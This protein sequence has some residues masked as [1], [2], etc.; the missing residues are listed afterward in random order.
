[1]PGRLGSQQRQRAVA[2]GKRS[3]MTIPHD[4]LA[5]S[6]AAIESHNQRGRVFHH[7]SGHFL[8]HGL[9]TRLRWI[10]QSGLY[11]PAWSVDQPANSFSGAFFGLLSEVSAQKTRPEPRCDTLL[12]ILVIFDERIG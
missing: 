9:R 8:R 7:L 3:A 11:E 6:C 10:I 5:G 1:M 12:T 4:R 2:F